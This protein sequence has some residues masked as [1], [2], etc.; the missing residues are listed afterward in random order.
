MAVTLMG[1]STRVD[2]HRAHSRSPRVCGTKPHNPDSV[3]A[4]ACRR[5][6]APPASTPA[7]PTSPRRCASCPQW[8][9]PEFAAAPPLGPGI[10]P[11]QGIQPDH[12]DPPRTRVG[13]HV[14]STTPG[15]SQRPA[16]SSHSA[17]R[18][19]RLAT[20]LRTPAL[21]LAPRPFFAPAS[22]FASALPPSSPCPVLASARGLDLRWPRASARWLAVGAPALPVPACSLPRPG[23]RRTHNPLVRTGAS[24]CRLF[25]AD[26]GP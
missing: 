17:A 26:G 25:R 13:S 11:A 5:V 24:R 15:P 8:T 9:R 10:V 22:P 12:R 4:I 6:P 19:P 23:V 3:P 14:R 18:P 1:L 20:W 7:R 2:V 16:L 21:R